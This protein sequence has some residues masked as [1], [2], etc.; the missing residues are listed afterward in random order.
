MP[1]A[2]VD[3]HWRFT[4]RDQ[5]QLLSAFYLFSLDRVRGLLKV[6]ALLQ[7]HVQGSPLR[8]ALMPDADFSLD[9]V[10]ISLLLPRRLTKLTFLSS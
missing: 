5:R 9:E 6:S 8:H 4:R 7:S 3:R 1:T 2:S 10:S